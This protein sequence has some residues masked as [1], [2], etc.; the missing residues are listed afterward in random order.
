MSALADEATIGVFDLKSQLSSV[1]EHVLA[2]QIYTVTRHG[3]PIAR[4]TPISAASA[5]ERR[6]AAARMIEARRGRKLGMSMKDAI[7]QGRA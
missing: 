3:H 1:L 6:A 2:G 4:I 5:D 7:A